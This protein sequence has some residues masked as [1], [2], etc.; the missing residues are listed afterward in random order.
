[1]EGIS[2]PAP[3]GDLGPAS[4]WSFPEAPHVARSSPTE[5]NE[6]QSSTTMNIGENPRIGSQSG[7][8]GLIIHAGNVATANFDRVAFRLHRWRCHM[9][10]ILAPRSRVPS[11]AFSISLN[12]ASNFPFRLNL[13]SSL[14]TEGA[15]PTTPTT[16][17]HT[18]THKHIFFQL[19]K[20]IYEKEMLNETAFKKNI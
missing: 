2:S 19:K 4:T 3:F 9:T 7:N 12:F 15:K 14:S 16:H 8:S 20:K 17:T 11:P 13:F 1:M 10:L 5:N 6:F 18:H